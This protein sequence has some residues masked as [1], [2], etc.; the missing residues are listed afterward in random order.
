VGR[1]AVPSSSCCREHRTKRIPRR[2][3]GID[4]V[5]EKGRCDVY[6]F[7]VGCCFCALIWLK[8]ELLEDSWLG[9]SVEGT[10]VSG[11]RQTII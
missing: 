11:M 1:V 4:G 7:V 10:E 9:S 3:G 5:D 2:S 8:P 6:G